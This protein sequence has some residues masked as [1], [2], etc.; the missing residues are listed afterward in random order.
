MSDRDDLVDALTDL[1]ARIDWPA[2]PAGMAAAVVDQL[3]Q[4]SR[5]PV[6]IGWRRLGYATAIAAVVLGVLSFSPAARDAIAGMLEAAGIRLNLVEVVPAGGSGLALGSEIDL[7]EADAAAGFE[8]RSPAGAEPGRP[9][10]VYIDDAGWVSMIW[11]GSEALPAA[12]GSDVAVLLTQFRGPPIGD[13]GLKQIGP[14]SSV[15]YVDVDGELAIWIDGVPH[16]FSL[17]GEDGELIEATT[18]LAANVL[19]W[20]RGGINYRLETTGD[21]ASALEIAERLEELP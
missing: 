9:E 12:A 6:S 5:R 10:T 21:L 13:V 15:R 18:R 14:N 19:L 11:V 20:D 8:L 7:D 4:G 16:T 17:I 3:Q 2:P 1:A